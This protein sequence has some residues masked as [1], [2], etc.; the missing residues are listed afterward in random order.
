MEILL[1]YCNQ[2]AGHQVYKS[3]LNNELDRFPTT[4]LEEKFAI[5]NKFAY[6]EFQENKSSFFPLLTVPSISTS[7]PQWQ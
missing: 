4:L 1:R 7:H 2:M 6:W 3:I 5:L